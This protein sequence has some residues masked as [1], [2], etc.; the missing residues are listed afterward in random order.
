MHFVSLSSSS[1]GNSYAIYNN[2]NDIILIDAGIGI[3]RIEKSFQE[4]SLK[5][6]H[7]N[8]ILIT[9]T[10]SDHIKGLKGLLNRINP[11]LVCNKENITRI[12]EY[13]A[14]IL[15]FSHNEQ[16]TLSDFAV[17][18]IEAYHDTPTNSFT[19]ESEHYKAGILTDTG[20]VNVHM[21]K[22]LKDLDFLAIESNY[23]TVHLENS[24]YPKMLQSRINSKYGHLSNE[25]AY[26]T[27]NILQHNKL[28]QILFVHLSKHSNSP[29]ILEE[30]YLN[31]LKK[32]FP[33]TDFSIAPY[34]SYS[35]IFNIGV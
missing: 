17:T 23:S 6:E 5:L 34:N 1:D 21:L 3:R 27:I 33:H 32:E 35:K 15:S 11:F 29:N 12:K 19:F 30:S 26:N 20:H 14:D 7:I 31:I 4:L 8:Y 2:P 13:N 18:P 22:H 24:G 10:H 28:K 25:Q 16:F 9:H